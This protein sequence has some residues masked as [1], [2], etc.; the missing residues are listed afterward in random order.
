MTGHSEKN[1]T[2]REQP[3][4]RGIPTV[5]MMAMPADT[6]WLG[7]IFGGW[8]MSHADIAGAVL[9]Y[10]RAE[11]KVVTVAV[12]NFL[13]LEPV[14]IG[15]I[16]SFYAEIDQIGTTSITMN[17]DILSERPDVAGPYENIRVATANITYVHIDADG[18]PD[19]V[20]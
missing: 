6:N 15:D 2:K 14:F 20:K 19:K 13:F 9:A 12:N 18:N 11:G 7:D 16:V 1:K 17:I 8:L 5:R 10:R 3:I 4:P